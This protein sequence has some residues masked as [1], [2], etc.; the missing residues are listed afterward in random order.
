M[1]ILKPRVDRRLNSDGVTGMQFPAYEYICACAYKIIGEHFFIARLFSFILF[2]TSL[3]IVYELLFFISGSHWAGVFGAWSFCWSPELFYYCITALP[4]VMALACALGGLFCF[5]KWDDLSLNKFYWMSLF[6]ISLAGLIKIQYLMFGGI[7]AVIVLKNFFAKK[8]SW[9]DFTALCFFGIVAVGLSISWYQYADFLIEKSN[10]RDFGIE[11]R[12][13][14]SYQQAI[15]V[16]KDNLI[17]DLPELILNYAG[18]ILFALGILSFF[19]HK[20]WRHKFFLS[21][22]LMSILY[23]IYHF[24]ELSQMADHQYYMI[25]SI[26]LLVVITSYGAKLL[27]DK[28][29]IIALVILIIAQPVLACIRILPARW[30]NDNRGVPP[31]LFNSK[32]RNELINAVPCDALCL[33]GPDVSGCIY[34]YFLHKKGFGY[35]YSDDL[36]SKIYENNISYMDHCIQLGAKYIYANDSSIM[37]NKKL[38][39]LF[40]NEIKKV[41]SFYVIKLKK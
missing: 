21:M 12:P 32:T 40:D 34:F 18:T 11:I 33:A 38:Q 3:W 23:F 27:W 16:L 4:D 15:K 6:L 9:K 20:T 14:K 8:Y 22:L 36:A 39:P 31:E 1:N 10:L 5:L 35:E 28:K 13:A 30:L 19:I 7:I 29:L 17:S 25:P 2:S 41:E 26:F 37:R 24:V